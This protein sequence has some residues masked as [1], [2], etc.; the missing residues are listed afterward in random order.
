MRTAGEP[1][2]SVFE[3]FRARLLGPFT[4]HSIPDAGAAGATVTAP[5]LGD[6]ALTYAL[7]YS[8]HGHPIPVR[9][10]TRPGPDYAE[11]YRHFRSRCT[12]GMP[13]GPVE[14]LPPE[15]VGSSFMSEGYQQKSITPTATSNTP[16][17][18]WRQIQ[19]I[20]PSNAGRNVFHF[21]V[22]SDSALP[23]AYTIRMGQGRGTLVAVD[24]VGPAATCAVNAQ[25]VEDYLGRTMKN[26]P[27]TGRLSLL[28]QYQ[29]YLGVPSEHAVRLLSTP[30]LSQ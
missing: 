30:R 1:V 6:I 26:V 3:S 18:P 11:D 10:G 27:H 2:P 12:V 29:V 21:S 9:F 16:W 7:H 25:A 19:S 4:Y 28:A 8:V 23:R 17:R 22:V 20:A 13:T 24:K 14:M 15:F 5:F